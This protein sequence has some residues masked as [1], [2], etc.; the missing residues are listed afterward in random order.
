MVELY[1]GLAHYPLPKISCEDGDKLVYSI[2]ISRQRFDMM[3]DTDTYRSAKVDIV[4]LLYPRDKIL[5]ILLLC[6]TEP[7]YME[8]PYLRF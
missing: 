4:L 5:L 8:L 6:S 7:W 1:I 2:Y 3:N